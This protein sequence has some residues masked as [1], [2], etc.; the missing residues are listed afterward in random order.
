MDVRDMEEE[1]K[2]GE[3]DG[4]G[5]GFFFEF[6]GTNRRNKIIDDRAAVKALIRK[7]S[8]RDVKQG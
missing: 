8:I 2:D 1:G 7:H 3:G 5:I 4:W 6:L